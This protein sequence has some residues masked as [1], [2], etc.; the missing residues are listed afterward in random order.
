MDASLQ[1]TSFRPEAS[2]YNVNL[3]KGCAVITVHLVKGCAVT[4]IHL[5]ERL[6]IPYV[7]Y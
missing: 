7:I 1:K 3:V 4:K 5:I 2:N 6:L